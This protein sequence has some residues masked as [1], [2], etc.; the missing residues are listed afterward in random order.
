MKK[1]SNIILLLIATFYCNASYSLAHSTAKT[2]ATVQ[3]KLKCYD[4]SSAI[5][6]YI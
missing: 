3:G 5:I 2:D 1:I 6:H 4:V